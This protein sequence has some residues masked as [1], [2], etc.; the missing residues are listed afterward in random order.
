MDGKLR[1]SEWAA[2]LLTGALAVGTLL[3]GMAGAEPEPV[4]AAAWQPA[5]ERGWQVDLNTADARTLEALPGI[6]PV[7][8]ERI[9]AYRE[10]HGPFTRPEELKNVS[11]IGEQTYESMQMY[12]IVEERP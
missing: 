2:L 10:E 7:L 6:G 4:T 12:L 8:A 11:G 3:T 5:P 1:K 9:L